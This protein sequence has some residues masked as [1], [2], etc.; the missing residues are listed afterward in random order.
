MPAKTLK[1]MVFDIPDAV[2]RISKRGVP[3][4]VVNSYFSICWFNTTKIYR[5]FSEYATQD[6][7][8]IV[9][10]KTYD[11]VINFFRGECQKNF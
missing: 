1:D 11:E 9:D 7:H 8:K 5:I 2:F 4:I 6:N 3:H 10:C